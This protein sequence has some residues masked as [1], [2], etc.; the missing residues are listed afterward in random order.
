[1]IL[2][3]RMSNIMNVVCHLPCNGLLYSCGWKGK[4]TYKTIF[5]GTGLPYQDTF[6]FLAQVHYEMTLKLHRF[7]D[8][9]RV[10][11]IQEH[12]SFLDWKC[13]NILRFLLSGTG[14]E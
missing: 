5:Q 11:R 10:D 2:K 14:Q 1:M 12:P 13:G 6:P 3:I 9:F 4:N 8:Y 7:M